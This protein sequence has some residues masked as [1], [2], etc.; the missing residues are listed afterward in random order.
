[1]HALIRS[2]LLTLVLLPALAH[3]QAYRCSSNGTT[4]YSDR[5]CAG[6]S[7]R[8]NIGSLGPLQNPTASNY[9]SS[10]SRPLPSAPRPPD[11]T[12]YLNSE[13]ASIAEAIRTAPTRGVRGDVLRG[14]YDEY[15]QKCAMEDRE[16]RER[17][18]QDRRRDYQ[19]RVAEREQ[20]EQARQ[21]VQKQAN[22][23]AGMRDVIGLKRQREHELN[24][25]EI[26]ALRDLERN[27]NQTCLSR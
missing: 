11:H 2:S 14:L 12:K 10:Y 27:Y 16:A 5:P 4:Y 13:C 7:H 22:Q 9:P 17:L 1:M 19:N 3:A 20:A 18:N 21:Q 25:K 15:S 24:A 26:S 23:C 6:E 8:T